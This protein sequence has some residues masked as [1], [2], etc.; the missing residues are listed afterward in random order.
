VGTSF[1]FLGFSAGSY[2]ADLGT[3]SGDF[4]RHAPRTVDIFWPELDIERFG[5][6]VGHL[7]FAFGVFLPSC[8]K[9]VALAAVQPTI[10]DHFRHDSQPSSSKLH[11]WP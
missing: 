5:P 6:P 11:R 2:F 8:N 10:G 3:P 1:H 7:L 4:V 9:R